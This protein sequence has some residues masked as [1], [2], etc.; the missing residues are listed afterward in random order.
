MYV[1]HMLIF[2][3]SHCFTYTIDNFYHS[4]TYYI[5]N[6]VLWKLYSITQLIHHFFTKKSNSVFSL[7]STAFCLCLFIMS[8][9]VNIVFILF[10]DLDNDQTFKWHPESVQSLFDTSEYIFLSE[11]KDSPSP[12]WV[13]YTLIPCSF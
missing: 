10:Y 7:N 1:L 3:A 8:S 2:T 9:Q 6:Q 4:V 5:L 12:Y 13:S 11:L